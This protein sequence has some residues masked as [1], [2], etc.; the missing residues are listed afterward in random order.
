MPCKTSDYLK[1]DDVFDPSV[2]FHNSASTKTLSAQHNNLLEF[3]LANCFMNGWV[4]LGASLTLHEL[5]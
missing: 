3:L 4:D 1:R 5:V 2:C